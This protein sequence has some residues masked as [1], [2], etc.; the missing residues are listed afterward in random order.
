MFLFGCDSVTVVLLVFSLAETFDY[1]ACN[2]CYV[3]REETHS[4][5]W[6]WFVTQK[7]SC[8]CDMFKFGGHNDNV[9]VEYKT[10]NT[11]FPSHCSP[12]DETQTPSV[13]TTPGATVTPLPIS[14]M[15]SNPSQGEVKSPF[16]NSCEPKSST[17]YSSCA[18]VKANSHTVNGVY[19]LTVG[20]NVIPAYCR[21]AYTPARLVIQKRID[22]EQSFYQNWTT[23]ESGF[24]D[25][26]GSFWWGNANIKIVTS[27]YANLRV[28]LEK[29]AGEV[30]AYTY[31]T[32]RVVDPDYTLDLG[33]GGG[34]GDIGDSLAKSN[35]GTFLTHDHGSRIECASTLNLHTGWW[36]SNDRNGKDCHELLESNLNGDYKAACC[37]NAHTV[38][39]MYDGVVWK[40]WSDEYTSMKTTDMSINI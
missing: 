8:S 20:S 33:S 3:H 19:Y 23:Y 2:N 9:A 28:R 17:V 31:P 36:F 37:A 39:D 40:S 30:A 6:R 29:F 27:T 25:L 1:V 16:I 15:V 26:C 12:G 5:K 13:P 34:H 32:F 24:G 11:L 35:P 38:Q 21:L 18:D 22:G 7:D 14:T 4:I 10:S